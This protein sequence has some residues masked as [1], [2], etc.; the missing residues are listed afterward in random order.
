MV[1]YEVGITL[2]VDAESKSEAQSVALVH[3]KPMPALAEAVKL[4]GTSVIAGEPYA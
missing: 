1:L 4:T 2:V 3:I